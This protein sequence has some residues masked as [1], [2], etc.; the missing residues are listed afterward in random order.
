MTLLIVI[1]FIFEKKMEYGICSQGNNTLRNCED[2]EVTC[3]G[4]VRL[5]VDN[6]TCHSSI[7]FSKVRRIFY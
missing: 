4:T 5:C 7:M 1:T 6:D 3:G 2:F